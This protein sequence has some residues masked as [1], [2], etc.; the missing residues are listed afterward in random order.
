ME[1]TRGESIGKAEIQVLR[2]CRDSGLGKIGFTGWE[3]SLGKNSGSTAKVCRKSLFGED[4]SEG[5]V[6]FIP[7]PH[8][9]GGMS[10]CLSP[11]SFL[12]LLHFKVPVH[13]H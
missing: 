8:H 5:R 6:L 1:V 9:C 7:S 3:E 2:C 11:P 10:P 13:A 12:F 4:K